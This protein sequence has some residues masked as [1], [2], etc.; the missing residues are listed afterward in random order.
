M[1][2]SIAGFQTDYNET[3]VHASARLSA[4]VHNIITI[5]M[6]IYT[7]L[8][9]LSEF[10]GREKVRTLYTITIPRI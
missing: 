9:S 4:V 3:M 2:I 5:T 8:S 7:R 1:Y 10:S 6:Y